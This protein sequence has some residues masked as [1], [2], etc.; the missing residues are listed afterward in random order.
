MSVAHGQS[1]PG[2]ADEPFT[3][4]HPQLIMRNMQMR[5]MLLAAM[6][7]TLGAGPAASFAQEVDSAPETA[8]TQWGF[9]AVAVVLGGM[10]VLV[11]FLGARRGHQD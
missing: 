7:L 10:V 2:Q 1:Q 3:L 9:I 11:S 6:A 4:M 5:N 8:L